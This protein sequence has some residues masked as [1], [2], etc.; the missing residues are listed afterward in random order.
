MDRA[1]LI[2]QLNP[3]D[4]DAFFQLRLRGL[5]AHPEAFAQSYQEALEKGPAQHD[6]IL[7]GVRAA[8]G[9][10]LLGAFPASDE[11]L[12]GVV[13]LMRGQRLKEQHKASVVGL[14]VA[15]EAGGRGIG[16]ALMEELLVRGAR[17]EG[18]RQIQL[19]V[20]STNEPAR[21]L[22][23]SLGFRRYGR[24]VDALCID[25]LFHDTDLMA[26]VL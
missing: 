9:D 24:E 8:D 4:R 22:Y 19:A 21:R 25:G 18:L 10:F 7:Q 2:R 3:A 14:Y 20:S 26:R 23:E 15:P 11:P 5:R 13:G 16:R 6:A 17:I 1:P 12:I